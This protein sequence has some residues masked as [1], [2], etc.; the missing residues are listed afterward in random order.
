M[1]AFSV[2][3]AI[4]LRAKLPRDSWIIGRRART[5]SITLHYN[6]PAVD[7]TRQSGAGLLD[8]LIADSNWQMRAGWGGTKNG[9]P[10][11][12]YHIV[13]CALGK[14]YLCCDLNEILWHCAHQDGN[15]NG[16]AVHF[17][18]GGAQDVTSAQWRSGVWV[19]EALRADFNVPRS[20]V[21][22]HL[23][24]KH[25]TACPGPRVMKRLNYYR[26][27]QPVE[28]PAP[29]VVPGLR[30]FQVLPTLA[31]PARVRQAPRIHLPDG[32]EVPVAGR[33][34]PG[35]PIF[36]DVIKT[37]GEMVEGSPNWAHMARVPNEQ[38]DLGFIHTSLLKELR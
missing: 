24:W 28:L 13:V 22:G 33:L 1:S 15:T 11:L 6:G 7:G 18:I 34:K 30:R 12:M 2:L 31:V 19:V 21:Y 35:T 8:Q 36:V 3:P 20:R 4:D 26:L 29:T 5:T 38:A 32:S 16:L 23:E 27:G 10:H 17:P 14:I 25:A 9:A 37:D